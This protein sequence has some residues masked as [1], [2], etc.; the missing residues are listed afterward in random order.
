VR[1]ARD[2]QRQQRQAGDQ[3]GDGERVAPTGVGG[4]D[5]PEYQGAHAQRR[6]QRA[7]GVGFATAWLALGQVARRGEHH[8]GA[9]GQVDEEANAPRQPAGEDAADHEADGGGHA[10]DGR[11]VGD[12][13]GALLAL[14]EA[15]L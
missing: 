4:V 6:L 5:D 15:C 13:A 7:H 2:E 3:W 9:G 14:V 1:D 11:I 12:S 10:G 8:G